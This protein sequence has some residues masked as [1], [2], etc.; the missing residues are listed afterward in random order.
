M[1]SAWLDYDFEGTAVDGLR[2][3]AGIRHAGESSGGA[4][5]NVPSYTVGD[6]M[7]SYDINES[8]TAQLNV[9]NITDEEYVASC[10]SDFWCYY[11][12]SRSVIGSVKYRW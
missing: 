5:I 7:A 6:A 8:W 10:E 12:E 2:V 4:T 1:A 9:N 3:G 11:G